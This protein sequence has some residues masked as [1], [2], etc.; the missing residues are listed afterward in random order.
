M[1][2]HRAIAAIFLS[3]IFASCVIETPIESDPP[4]P[5]AATIAEQQPEPE[6]VAPPETKIVPQEEPVKEPTTEPTATIP[7]SPKP[8]AL[9]PIP[10][11]TAYILDQCGTLWGIPADL[12]GEYD[13]VH[14][15]I[16]TADGTTIP[17]SELDVFAI[18][19]ILYITRT[20]TID[21]NPAIDYYRQEGDAIALVD[22]VPAKPEES[23]DRLDSPAWL[24]ETTVLSGTEYSYLYNRDPDMIQQQ[25]N[26]G[27][28]GAFMRRYD[29][30]SGY[31]VLDKGVIIM[32]ESGAFFWPQ[33]RACGNAV[34]EYGRLWK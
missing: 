18:D 25:G 32:T 16:E 13:K 14:I 26:A 12:Q 21:G 29:R 4:E 33:N 2:H 7:E 11:F 3:V 27:G 30:I 6:T 31:A 23:R 24:I 1:K 8:V 17:S 9:R 28:K 10:A 5:V 22:S 15:I 19:G 34:S 20:H